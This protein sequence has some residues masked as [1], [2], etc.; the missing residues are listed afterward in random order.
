MIFEPFEKPRIAVYL[1][2]YI[3][4]K[5]KSNIAC[6]NLDNILQITKIMY[7]ILGLNDILFMFQ[8]HG[9]LE[10]IKEDSGFMSKVILSEL[11]YVSPTDFPF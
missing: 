10:N 2:K 5:K 7:S 1:I 6:K 8:I 3:F 4:N 11:Y 9:L